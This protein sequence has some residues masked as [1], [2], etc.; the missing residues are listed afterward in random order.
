[1][2]GAAEAGVNLGFGVA[3]FLLVGGAEGRNILIFG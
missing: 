1:V 3:D 2:A